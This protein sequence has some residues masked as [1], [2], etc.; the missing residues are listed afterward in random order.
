MSSLSKQVTDRSKSAEAVCASLNTHHQAIH[1]A[2]ASQ[3]GAYLRG[4]EQMPDVSLLV[5]LMARAIEDHAA[6]LVDADRHLNTER[7]QDSAAREARDAALSN[8]RAYV[9]DLM[10]TVRANFPPQTLSQVLLH[11]APPSDTAAFAEWLQR[12]AAQIRAHKWPAPRNP[13]V[14]FDTQGWADD[15]DAFS[16]PIT[17]A[18]NALALDLRETEDA[19]VRRDLRQAA[20]D[21]AFIA[22]ART[23]EALCRL[24]R[25]PH[26]SN[27]GDRIRPS[28]R[29]PGQTNALADQPASSDPSP[30]TTSD[31][32]APST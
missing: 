26:L 32:S 22:S 27:I 6:Q 25:D 4:G 3:L 7:T 20:Y 5:R 31:Q 28:T 16:A 29:R 24:A 9:A 17:A 14:T 2:T 23:G 18:L 30:A 1:D 10:S 15:L 19:L 8:A 13:R 21:A 11:S 12:V